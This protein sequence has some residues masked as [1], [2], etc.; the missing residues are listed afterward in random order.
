MILSFLVIGVASA[1][2]SNSTDIIQENQED[3]LSLSDNS[4]ENNMTNDD[5]VLRS[6]NANNESS[7]GGELLS[8]KKNDDNDL[9]SAQ[10][11]VKSVNKASSKKNLKLTVYSNFIKKGKS[12]C[13]FLT[14]SKGN[15]V[16]NKKVN[17]K[18]GGKNYKFIT[19]NTG[20]FKIKLDNGKGY[21]KMVVSCKGD[22][23]YNAFAKTVKVYFQDKL[24]MTIGNSKLLKKGYLRVYLKYADKPLSYKNTKIAIGKKVFKQKTN[25]EGFV[26]IKPKVSPSTYTVFF[27]FSRYQVAKKIKCCK[28]NVLDPTRAS[29]P[30][31]NGRPNIDFMPGNY[32]MGDNDAKYTLKKA[33]YKEAI[34]RDSYCLFLYGKLPKFTFFKTKA[35]PKIYHIIKREKWNVIEREINTEI[36][37]MNRYNYWPDSVTVSLKDKS[38][39]YPEVRD[40][41]NTRS[42]CGP[43]A[44]SVCSQAL[45]KFNSEKYFQ[46]EGNVVKGIDIPYLKALLENNGF[47]TH[48]FN[49]KTLDNAVKKLSKGGVALIAYLPYH[50]VAVIDVSPDGNEILVSNSY[51]SYDEGCKDVPTNWVSLDYFKTKFANTGLV[52]K[53]NYNLR[54][55]QKEHTINFYHSMVPG[56]QRQ[57]VHERI[58]DIGL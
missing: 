46:E 42:T 30:T 43:A 10:K 4:L 50:Y 22:R 2:D 51:G 16:A 20:K 15:A 7:N 6:E 26:I 31:K 38:Y 17:V 11:K 3:A 56:W 44:A 23:K 37:I 32:I 40:I 18:Y 45:K 1:S 29:I 53:L 47:K 55:S 39:T 34:S 54:D 27:K 49:E 41:Q 52:V 14:D 35:S 36:V 21:A 58:V 33:H 19:T 48:Y 28:G 57:N 5:G 13:M 12:Y 9:L 25:S 24:S 8:L